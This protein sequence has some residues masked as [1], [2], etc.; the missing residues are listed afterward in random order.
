MYTTASLAQKETAGRW[1]PL[2]DGELRQR[3][4]A[5]VGSIAESLSAA[6][7]PKAIWD[8]DDPTELQLSLL[9]SWKAEVALFYAYAA[10]ALDNEEFAERAFNHLNEAIDEA[11][12]RMDSMW[13]FGGL[14]GLGW[15]MANLSEVFFD[16][17]QTENCA[18]VDELLNEH[19]SQPG[20]Q[21]HY[22]LILGLVG[23]G[24]YALER[25]QQA[26]V[27]ATEISTRVINKLWETAERD[28]QQITWHTSPALLPEWQSQICP[29]GYYNLG[30]AHGVPGIIA[31]LGKNISAGI[32]ME[33]SRHLL[34]GAVRWLLAQKGSADSESYFGSWAGAGIEREESKVAWCYGDLGIGMAL[35]SAAKC[36]GRADWEQEAM[37]VLLKAA[38]RTFESAGVIDVSL[39]HGAAGNAHIFNRAY[40]ATGDARFRTAALAWYERA[41]DF[42]HF[43][44]GVGGF[45]IAETDDTGTE[46]RWRN[47]PGLLDGIA[48][49]GLSLLAACTNSEPHWDRSLLISIPPKS[50]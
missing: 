33:R 11:A 18:S 3:T 36:T 47:K 1:Q 37:T 21:S 10:K 45:S 23:H 48:G 2:L 49:V 39:C 13:L 4:L 50:K 27:S 43:G 19:L 34:E 16:Q 15:I 6:T 46:I 17:D 25:Q 28:G 40:Q 29:N 8:T 30:L 5:A 42:Q 24:V 44:E 32:E 38:A 31:L 26:A 14:T 9:T 41:L 20:W 12:E 7:T 35:L 22:D